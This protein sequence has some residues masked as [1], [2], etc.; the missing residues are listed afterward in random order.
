MIFDKFG[1]QKFYVSRNHSMYNPLPGV[2]EQDANEWWKNTVINIRETLKNMKIKPEEI[3]GVGITGHG[4]DVICL[5]RNGK[6]LRPAIY[7]LDTRAS[8]YLKELTNNFPIGY[9]SSKLYPNLL[10]LRDNEPHIEKS[11]SFV[12]DSKEFIAYK[13]GNQATYDNYFFNMESA[14]MHKLNHQ[15]N[16]P[17]EWFGQSHGYTEIAMKVTEAASRETGLKKGTPVV[18]GP[19]D[20]FSSIAGS[21]S[22]EEGIA[23]DTAGTTEVISVAV[24]K[25]IP[26]AI[27]VHFKPGFWFTFTSPPLGIAHRWFVDRLADLKREG[28]K[29]DRMYDFVNKEAAKSPPGSLGLIFLP[30]LK[31]EFKG[32]PVKG[33]FF[34]ISVSHELSHFSRAVLE[35]ISF[36]LREIIENTEVNSV[37]I[38]EVRL[39]GGGAKN[40]LWNQIRADIV[41]KDFVVLKVLESTSLGV[42]LLT[43]IGTGIHHNFDDATHKMVKVQKRYSP[44]KENQEKYTKYYSLYKQI[45]SKNAKYFIKL[46]N[47][48]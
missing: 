16:I 23:V 39:G 27:F 7:F 14:E 10:W 1:D 22:I 48:E 25:K 3:S 6:V 32:P 47:L 19:C 9:V 38:K 28:L 34:G 41:G 8:A 17:K 15:L 33:A 12:L 45:Y 30:T 4:F 36:R 29:K 13:L 40:D 24:S 5:D 44:I 11:I 20:A 26:S 42:A 2:L 43:S 31:E 46:K 37:P 21:G 35:G 18:V